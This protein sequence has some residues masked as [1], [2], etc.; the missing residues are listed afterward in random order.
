MGRQ[1]QQNAIRIHILFPQSQ[2][3]VSRRQIGIYRIKSFF[4]EPEI[5]IHL[6]L[7]NF[8][9]YDV[10]IT[11][12]S[13]MFTCDFLGFPFR[14]FDFVFAYQN[15]SVPSAIRFGQNRGQRNIKAD[16]LIIYFINELYVFFRI[17]RSTYGFRSDDSFTEISG[18]YQSVLWEIFLYEL[19]GQVLLSQCAGPG[20]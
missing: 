16:R 9:G 8:L 18:F 17:F 10:F 7:G 4:P 6:G 3:I 11:G 13:V 2:I 15:Q 14:T 12:I 5:R 19:G 20:Q 1:K